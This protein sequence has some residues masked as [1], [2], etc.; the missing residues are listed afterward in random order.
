MGDELQ[1]NQQFFQRSGLVKKSC[2]TVH[3]KLRDTSNRRRDYHTLHR[4]GLHETDRNSLAV[5]GE[6]YDIG[7]RV[8]ARK[9][10]APKLA[11][12][13]DIAFQIQ[14]CDELLKGRP[15]RSVS[16]DCAADV[17]AC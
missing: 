14:P 8:E 12:K 15:L 1:L 16:G 10:D 13:R 7:I 5:T 2:L 11:C 4:H 3:D 9:A 6:D 17:H